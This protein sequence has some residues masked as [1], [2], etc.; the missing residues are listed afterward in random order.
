MLKTLHYNVVAM[1]AKPVQEKP[2]EGF[3]EMQVIKTKDLSYQIN[4]GYP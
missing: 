4:G 3:Y 1:A 2:R